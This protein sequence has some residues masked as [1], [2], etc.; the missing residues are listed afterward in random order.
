M[1]HLSPTEDCDELKCERWSPCEQ[2]T[3]LKRTPRKLVDKVPP[4]FQMPLADIILST[5]DAQ[6]LVG[7]SANVA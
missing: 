5:R 6:V 7:H 1:V 4:I 2:Y 3:I